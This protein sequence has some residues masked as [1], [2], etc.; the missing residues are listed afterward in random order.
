MRNLLAG[1]TLDL[2]QREPD[3]GVLTYAP[4]LGAR[5]TDAVQVAARVEASDSLT[6]DYHF[7]YTNSSNVGRGVQLLGAPAG[8][9]GAL[10]GAVLRFQGPVGAYPGT[11][12]ITNFGKDRMDAVANA[13]SAEPITVQGHSLTVKWKVDDV[14]TVKSITGYRQFE[15]KPTAYDLAAAGGLRFSPAQLGALLTGNIPAIM[16]PANQPGPNDSF[17]PLLSV[18]STSQKQFTEELQFLFDW[19]R[20]HL[21][22]GLFYFHENSPATSVLGIFQPVV[23]G[24]VVP[25]PL[26]AVF[27]S[28]VTKTRAI[29]DSMAG[30]GQLTWNAT[31]KLEFALGLR[32]TIDDR[33]TD[34]ISITKAAQAGGLVPGRTYKTSYERLN[35]TGIVTYRPSDD[36][37]AYAKVA[38]GY[39]AGGVLG[40]IPYGPESLTSY[41]LGLKSQLFGNRLRA[42][43]AAFYSDYKDLQVRTFVNGI[44]NYQNAGKARIWGLEGE[45]Q[46]APV[47]GLTLDANFGY[48]N[49]KYQKFVSG[50]VDIADIINVTYIPKWTARFSGKYVL[51]EL[52]NGA[53]LY[54]ST[55]NRYRSGL[56]LNTTPTGS[57]TLDALA[58]EKAYV[59]SDARI[60]VTSLPIAGAKIDI[61]G[62]VK[63]I[64][65]T[66]RAAFGPTV[67]SQ[68]IVPDMGRTYGI[69]LSFKF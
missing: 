38:S 64:F 62:W 50:G 30:Y 41:E 69:D 51:A 14:L 8:S 12:G 52:D 3:F 19:N 7:D 2:R 11:G 29:N 57:A 13:T 5:R 53:G 16:A 21:T 63:N 28:G 15:E 43:F 26:D 55:D 31:D 4:R 20:F 33:A 17:F 40:A 45:F 24:V 10:A 65:D 54:V 58:Y 42:N 25:T 67:I 22:S 37:T 48:T 18:R 6:I 9:S 60:G 27:G 1:K 68:V 44:D 49:F 46:A 61:S 32:Y 34:L 59:L 39:V 23:N 47:R 36:V 56:P 66:D 35:Y